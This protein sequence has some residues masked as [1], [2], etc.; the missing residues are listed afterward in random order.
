MM[1]W[2][3]FREAAFNFEVLKALDSLFWFSSKKLATP[4]D[5]FVFNEIRPGKLRVFRTRDTN[6]KTS[7]PC[8]HHLA[9]SN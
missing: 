8:I 2:T 9:G 5:P 6:N 3:R 1:F 7:H 4:T